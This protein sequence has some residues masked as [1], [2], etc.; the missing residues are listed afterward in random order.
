MTKPTDPLIRFWDKVEILP[1]GCWIWT[2][3]IQGHGYAHFSIKRC[4][5][6]RAH[7]WLWEQFNGP[8]P[9]G[10]HLHHKCGKKHCV[11]PAHLVAASPRDHILLHPE[12]V[13]A[14]EI[15]QESCKRGHPF[16]YIDSEGKR[17]C[18]ICEAANRREKRSN[19]GGKWNA[20][21]REYKRRK[22]VA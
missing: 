5:A 1:D 21:Q 12:S 19:D 6:V 18:H 20:Y 13:T 17:S 16:D 15:A 10:M 22:R 14:K 11:N 8:L 2:G 7:K 4:V 3:A 9:K